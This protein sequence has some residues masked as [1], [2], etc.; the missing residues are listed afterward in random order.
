MSQDVCPK[1]LLALTASHCLSCGWSPVQNDFKDAINALPERDPETGGV[2]I[3]TPE[4][5]REVILERPKTMELELEADGRVIV[6]AEG[7]IFL[8][9]L[10]VKDVTVL[11]RRETV[12]AVPRVRGALS[13]EALY[14]L[15]L[16]LEEE[17]RTKFGS[18]SNLSKRD[19]IAEWASL[20]QDIKEIDH[21]LLSFPSHYHDL[22]C[23]MVDVKGRSSQAQVTEEN[24]AELFEDWTSKP[25]DEHTPF[26][27]A[28]GDHIAAKVLPIMKKYG[29]R[30]T[31]SGGGGGEWH[32]GSHCT[33]G[34]ATALC[35]ALHTQ[36]G[37]LITRGIIY[38]KRMPW[39]VAIKELG[40]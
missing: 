38:L 2:N 6:K 16:K 33:E 14:E 9:A 32:M 12:N 1:C 15:K 7:H 8:R 30:L 31:D 27:V 20:T 10:G 22:R 26:P 35:C 40:E 19:Q 17:K 29:G 28:A 34:E 25:A 37:K 23:W 36:L 3:R 11:D 4:E 21:R 13:L 24:M 18:I 39:S 5:T